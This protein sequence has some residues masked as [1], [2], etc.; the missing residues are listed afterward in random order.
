[1][2]VGWPR[3]AALVLIFAAVGVWFLGGSLAKLGYVAIAACAIALVAAALIDR[4]FDA[5]RWWARAVDPIVLS[6]PF[7]GPWRVVSGGADP[8]HNRYS[9]SSDRLFAY[10]F[11]PNSEAA[12]WREVLAPCDGVIAWSGQYRNDGHYVSIETAGGF[13]IVANLDAT[14]A[15]RIAED[16]R[17]GRP[18][19]RWRAGTPG[20]GVTVHA[21]DRPHIAGDVAQG[22]PV[23]FWDRAGIA[24]VLEYGDVLG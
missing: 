20:A 10:E 6:S 7:H 5:G 4:R 8:R 17:A 2:N 18:I 21:Q 22:V 23:A 12:E 13:V 3:K 14:I 11:V 24:Q 9:R 15:V 19:G 1:M 16:V